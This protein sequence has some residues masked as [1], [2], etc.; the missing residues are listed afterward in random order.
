VIVEFLGIKNGEIIRRF[1]GE[2]N[3]VDYD[4]EEGILVDSMLYKYSELSDVYDRIKLIVDE[5]EWIN[6]SLIIIDFSSYKIGETYEFSDD[7]KSW[8]PRKLETIDEESEH[9]FI[10]YGEQGGLFVAT[11]LAWR[12]C[13]EVIK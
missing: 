13:R 9:P 2:C 3:Q 7:F 5:E 12:Y 10:T 11:K 6:K 4:L 8:R 1:R